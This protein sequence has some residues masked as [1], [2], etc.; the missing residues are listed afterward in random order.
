MKVSVNNDPTKLTV[1][2]RVLLID[3]LPDER[4]MY[5]YGLNGLGVAI[6]VVETK[7][8]L[9]LMDTVGADVIV[10]NVEG[11]QDWRLCEQLADR[12]ENVPVLVLTADVR[13]GLRNRERCR[14]ARNCAAFLAK[15]CTHLRLI[16]VIARV[17]GGERGIEI[18]E[19]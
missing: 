13:P 6:T 18:T 9:A 2:A 12:H 5:R 14:A 11:E 17:A 4:E 19:C 16:G 1:P 3:D 8:A 10:L 7:D 15:P